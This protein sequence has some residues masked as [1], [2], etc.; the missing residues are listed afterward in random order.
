MHLADVGCFAQGGLVSEARPQELPFRGVLQ[1]IENYSYFTVGFRLYA[2]VLPLAFK[3]SRAIGDIG[4]VVSSWR[5][6]SSRV[7]SA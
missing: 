1:S 6:A 3:M 5:I 4:I 7:R 2:D